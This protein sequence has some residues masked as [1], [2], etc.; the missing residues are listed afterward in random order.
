MCDL[1]ERVDSKRTKGDT[2]TEITESKSRCRSHRGCFVK[3]GSKPVL[4]VDAVEIFLRLL[5]L[6]ENQKD[7]SLFR[8]SSGGETLAYVKALAGW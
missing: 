1:W 3:C 4:L 8:V 5:D 2:M 7:A 6:S